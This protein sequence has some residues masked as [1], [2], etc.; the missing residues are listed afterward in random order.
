MVPYFINIQNLSNKVDLQVQNH[1]LTK[2]ALGSKCADLDSKTGVHVTSR[3]RNEA[4]NE[5][6][7]RINLAQSEISKFA[8]N[9][10]FYVRLFCVFVSGERKTIS[11]ISSFKRS[12]LGSMN[13]R[14]CSR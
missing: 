9:D 2:L 10:I 7:N 5:I 6:K 8:K 1:S 3:I 14:N 13:I 11:S 4:L 12:V